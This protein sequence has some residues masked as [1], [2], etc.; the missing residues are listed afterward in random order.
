MDKRIFVIGSDDCVLGFSLVGVSG[1]A[2]QNQDE[3]EGSLERALNDDSVALLLVSSDVAAWQRERIDA[4]KVSSMHPLVV[5]IP[6]PTKEATAPSLREF[7]QRAV[8]VNLGG[9]S[10]Q[11]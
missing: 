7:V 8:G 3:L 10:W 1:V 2:V 5:E 6:G 9:Q 4:L 11:G